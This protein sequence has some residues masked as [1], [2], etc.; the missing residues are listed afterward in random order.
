MDALTLIDACRAG[1]DRAIEE[2]ILTYQQPVYLL[3]LSILGDAMEAEEAAHDSFLAALRA[4]KSYRGEASLKTWLISV[5]VNVCR[6]R[7]RKRQARQRLWNT[8]TLLW[9][10]ADST[11]HPEQVTIED[12]IGDALRGL[13]REMDERLSLPLVLR[14]GHSMSIAEIARILKISERSVHVRLHKA[15]LHLR[16]RLAD[17]GHGL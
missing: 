9:P 12:E 10:T 15:H 14:Y 11:I 6:Q 5:T 3:A 16:A 17:R 1:D 8:L 7:L 2:L 4:L 13:V